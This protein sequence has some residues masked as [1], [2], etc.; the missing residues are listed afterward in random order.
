[1]SLSIRVP[2][3]KSMTQRAL[4]LGAMADGPVEVRG[5]LD[6]D[7]SRRLSEILA[8]LGTGI[9]W[10]SNRIELRAAP[11]QGSGQTLQCGNAGTALRFGACLALVADGE[12]LLGEQ[13]LGEIGHVCGM[14]AGWAARCQSS[15]CVRGPPA[16][17]SRV[18]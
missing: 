10:R 7:D 8:T 17:D 15:P 12:D 13:G 18:P 3:S 4:I 14:V 11:L 6:C 2:G 9:A 16:L 1:M 5:A